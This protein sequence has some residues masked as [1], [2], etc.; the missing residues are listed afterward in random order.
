MSIFQLKPDNLSQIKEMPFKLEREIQNLVEKNLG[1]LLGL[2][3][4]KS[5]FTISGTV[6]QLRIDTLA[7]DAKSKA[8]VI[9]EYKQDKSFSVVDQGYAY[10]SVMLNNKADFILEYNESS[11]K[12]LKKADV[13]WSQSRVI[14]ISQAFTPYQKEAINFKDLPIAL[15]E[16][17]QF[18]NQ[19]ISFEEIRKLNATESIKTVSAGNSAVDSVSKVVVVYTEND[20]LKDIPEDILEL[21]GQLR[22]RILELGNV[23][24][25]ATKLYV[26]FTVNGSNFTDIAIQKKALKLWINLPKGGLEDPYKLA[27]DVANIGHHGNGDYQLS[28]SNADKLDYIITLIKQGYQSKI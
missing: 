23:E 28:I 21:Y 14:F 12:V 27:R 5:E 24:I 3:F 17:K 6:Q 7:F 18:S 9:I 20:R 8:F 15:W 16:I 13:D 4:V 10:L 11:G 2:E 25:K 22:E 26:A 1:M 19:T